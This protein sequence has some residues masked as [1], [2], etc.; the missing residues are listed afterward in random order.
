MKECRPSVELQ[1][2]PIWEMS[3]KEKEKAFLDSWRRLAST[4]TT[5]FITS[6]KGRLT[7]AVVVIE[8]GAPLRILNRFSLTTG[9]GDAVQILD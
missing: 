4:P 6:S 3:Q 7:E 5:A 9:D 2:K 8:E 1:A